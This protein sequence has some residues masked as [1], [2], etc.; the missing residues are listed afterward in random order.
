M[1][2][3][4]PNVLPVSLAIASFIMLGIVFVFLPV[5]WNLIPLILIALV[6]VALF[7]RLQTPRTTQEKA[8]MRG[9]TIEI[10]EADL[11]KMDSAP[12]SE[13]DLGHR[14]NHTFGPI[15]A[16]MLIDLLDFTTFGPVGLVVGLPIGGLVGY[17][18]GR[19][20]GLS[21]KASLG[22][23][24]AASI[25]CTTPATEFIPLAT[26][27]GAYIR[28]SESRKHRDTDDMQ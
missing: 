26:I 3:S 17:W 27:V 28:F 19:S 8:S 1:K 24:L 23:A 20:L 12:Q 15:V 16:G 22:C 13:A 11:K 9:R 5:G 18:M 21:R 4:N 6:A 10:D 2:K 25:Y 14:L 7:I